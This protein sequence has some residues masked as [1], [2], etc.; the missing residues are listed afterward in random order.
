MT[1]D[2]ILKLVAAKKLVLD[3]YATG[4]R[5]IHVGQRG[6][7]RS[8]PGGRWF[9]GGAGFSINAIGV[10]LMLVTAAALG[11]LWFGRRRHKW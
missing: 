5:R 10:L 2:A 11:W 9:A 3:T 1:V 7:K 6:S 8:W 4:R